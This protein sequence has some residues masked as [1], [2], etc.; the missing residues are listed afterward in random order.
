MISAPQTKNQVDQSTMTAHSPSFKLLALLTTMSTTIASAAFSNRELSSFVLPTS[1]LDPM[2]PLTTATT[3]S[4]ALF[5]KDGA[6]STPDEQYREGEIF[7]RSKRKSNKSKRKQQQLLAP[8]VYVTNTASTT[9]A[10]SSA[11][12]KKNQKP[13]SYNLH[14]Q[15]QR[16]GNVVGTPATPEEL[17]NH[18][19]SIFSDFNGNTDFDFDTEEEDAE[20]LPQFFYESSAKEKDKAVMKQNSIML[21]HHPSLVLNANYLPLRMLPLSIWS[22]QDTV[23]A[24]LSGKAVVVDTYPD[25]FVRAVSLD[26]PVPSV[27]ALREFAPV[28]KTVSLFELAYFV[29]K[30]FISGLLVV[31]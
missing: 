31:F 30:L 16:S 6:D 22:W 27:I 29:K 3:P 25:L 18:V 26:I 4:T 9:S 12:I 28:G 21:D 17:A 7:V 14:K 23:K 5:Y 19:Q 24:V 15:Q 2:P 10:A 13:R 8:S 11:A 20:R 1:R